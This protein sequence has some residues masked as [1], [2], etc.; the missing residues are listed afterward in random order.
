MAVPD[1]QTLMLPFL[2]VM[3]DQKEHTFSEVETTL[4]T[5]YGLAEEERTELEIT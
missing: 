5:L 4:S 2:N 3:A 1:F